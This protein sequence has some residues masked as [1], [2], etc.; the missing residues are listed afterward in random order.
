MLLVAGD[1][2]ETVSSKLEDVKRIFNGDG[3]EEVVKEVATLAGDVRPG[4]E[5]G[6]EQ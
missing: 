2:F 5:K 6:H 3:G 1:S 4:K